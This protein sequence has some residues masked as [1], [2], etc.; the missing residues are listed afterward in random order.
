MASWTAFRLLVNGII[1]SDF[2]KVFGFDRFG[3]STYTLGSGS[4]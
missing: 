3:R 4:P 2:A 1:L